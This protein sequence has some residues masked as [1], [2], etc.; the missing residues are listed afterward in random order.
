MNKLPQAVIE[1]LG[2]YVYLYINPFDGKIFYVS[3]GQDDRVL[4]HLDDEKSENL[5]RNRESIYSFMVLN[6]RMKH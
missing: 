1:Q 4:S 5:V 3:K 6:Q 2:N